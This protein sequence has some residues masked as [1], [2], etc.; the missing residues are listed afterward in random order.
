MANFFEVTIM[1]YFC[2]EHTSYT[3]AYPNFWE[4]RQPLGTLKKV[5]YRTTS[6][7]LSNLVPL[8]EEVPMCFKML[9]FFP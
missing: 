6:L 5:A 4:A 8:L 1:I 7:S 9:I 2:T 3:A